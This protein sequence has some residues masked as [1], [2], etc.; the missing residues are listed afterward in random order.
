MARAKDEAVK[1]KYCKAKTSSKD[2]I[3]G[4]CWKKK[5]LLK[6]WH[7]VYKPKETIKIK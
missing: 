4:A 6:G 2:E 1:C 3:C 7:W 5:K